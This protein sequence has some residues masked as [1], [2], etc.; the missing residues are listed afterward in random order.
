MHPA[1]RAARRRVY[2]M[3]HADVH[4]ADADGRPVHPD[5]VRLTPRGVEQARAAAALFA[6]VA[7][8]AA[9]TS[10]LARTRQ[11]AEVLLA[12][13]DVPLRDDPAWREIQTGHFR[14]DPAE[15]RAAL[16][17]ALPADL[18]PGHSFLSGET[19]GQLLDRARAAW[20]AALSEKSWRGL[21]VVSHGILNRTL[22][23]SLL[24]APLGAVGL[25]EQDACC[26]NVI[27]V[28]DA[29]VPLVRLV[30]FTPADPLK[31]GTSLSSLEALA[32]QFGGERRPS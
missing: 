8:D 30:N 22:L 3:R 16:L 17:S 27:D 24:G 12:G 32:A 11:T 29:G 23:A 4:Y 6:D 15:V 28:D 10:G 9:V 31:H 1:P 2:L 5:H 7:L 13:R 20:G 25:I 18:S 19:F 21:L 14:P 26:V